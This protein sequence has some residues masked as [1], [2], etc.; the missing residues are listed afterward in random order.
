M[1]SVKPEKTIPQV[2]QEIIR[3]IFEEL[4]NPKPSW[5]QALR[6]FEKQKSADRIKCPACNEPSLNFWYYT[7]SSR[8]V[9]QKWKRFGDVWI[10]CRNC[11]RMVELHGGRIPDWYIAPSDECMICGKKLDTDEAKLTAFCSKECRKVHWFEYH[12]WRVACFLF[13]DLAHILLII[14]TLGIFVFQYPVPTLG[15]G[16]WPHVM[17]ILGGILLIVRSLL[18]IFAQSK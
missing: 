2:L 1:N 14:G 7:H 17:V 10:S 12:K 9:N 11:N 6:Q 3:E 8:N 15:W 16:S 13:Y 18:P 5:G 4:R